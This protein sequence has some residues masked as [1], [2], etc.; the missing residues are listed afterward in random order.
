MSYPTWLQRVLLQQEQESSFNQ[1]DLRAKSVKLYFLKLFRP[2]KIYIYIMSTCET[3]HKTTERILKCTKHTFY[4]SE[5]QVRI[6]IH[7]TF[8]ILVHAHKYKN[9]CRLSSRVFCELSL[10]V[11]NFSDG[12][13]TTNLTRE[14]N[15]CT[16]NIY[17]IKYYICRL[18]YITSHV[19]GN[20]HNYQLIK[21]K[22]IYWITSRS[23]KEANKRAEGK[24][25]SSSELW[26]SVCYVN[27][28]IYP[29]PWAFAMWRFHIKTH[30]GRSC[31]LTR[32][33]HFHEPYDSIAQGLFICSSVCCT[34]THVHW[35][36]C[37][38][39]HMYMWHPYSMVG[40]CN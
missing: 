21:Y 13:H 30:E 25:T 8:D 37:T 18:L 31:A 32:I 35:H 15:P 34:L 4:H 24:W 17:I 40:K 28:I 36:T 7:F 38:L 39:T 2:Y 3:H 1:P 27:W 33:L 9:T 20:T 26:R 23:I 14:F 12:F 22:D 19:L 29:S 16:Q 11:K 6:I 10:D 5:I